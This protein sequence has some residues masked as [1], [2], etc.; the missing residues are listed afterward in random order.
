MKFDLEHLDLEGI[1]TRT[2]ITLGLYDK[3][4]L[5]KIASDRKISFSK[6]VQEIICEWVLKIPNDSEIVPMPISGFTPP[7]GIDK[8]EIPEFLKK[9]SFAKKYSIENIDYENLPSIEELNA[10]F[11][12]QYD[13]PEYASWRQAHIAKAKNLKLDVKVST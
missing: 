3:L 1:T 10:E 13:N 12:E 8:I 4:V 7:P 5:K 6:L 11:P 9:S 2:K